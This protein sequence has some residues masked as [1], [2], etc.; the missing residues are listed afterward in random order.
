[1]YKYEISI[2]YCGLRETE[3]RSDDLRFLEVGLDVVDS[4]YVI[5]NSKLKD[6]KWSDNQNEAERV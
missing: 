4:K 3:S 1:M 5:V 6:T 2:A